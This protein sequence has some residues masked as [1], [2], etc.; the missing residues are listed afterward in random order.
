MTTAAGRLG[1][2][3]GQI[4]PAM[5]DCLLAEL[6]ETLPVG[7]PPLRYHPLPLPLP[8]A[9][10]QDFTLRKIEDKDNNQPGPI[11]LANRLTPDILPFIFI[12]VLEI[13][14]RT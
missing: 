12:K 8:S 11:L 2:G 10:N 4:V 6:G 1:L 9:A 13:Y 14:H 3:H 5:K 7:G